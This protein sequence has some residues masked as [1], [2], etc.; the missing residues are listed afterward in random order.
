[1]LDP[2]ALPRF[3]DL[4][5]I[6]TDRCNLSC[7]FCYVPRHAPRTMPAELALRA[8]DLLL[9]RAPA[10]SQPSV[11]FFGGEPFLEPGLM[12]R[13]MAHGAKRR[14]DLRFGAPTNGTLVDDRALELVQRHRLDLALSVDAGT[15]GHTIDRIAGRIDPLRGAVSIARM[16]V[17]PRN[18]DRLFEGIV[19]LFGRGLERIMHQPALEAPWPAAAVASW[20]DQ[21]R[22]LADWACERYAARQPLPELVVLE[23]II[24]R[25]ERQTPP[26]FCGAGSTQLAVD[27]AGRVFGCFRSAYDPR[28]GRLVLADLNRGEVNEPLLAAYARLDPVRARP[29]LA[30]RDGSCRGCP[31]R[32]GCTVYCP[33]TGHVRCGDLRAVPADACVL[34][35]AQVEICRDISRR[36]K[37]IDRS[38]RRRVGARVA[39][40]TLALG[41]AAG[42]DD[43]APQADQSIGGLCPMDAAVDSRG[44]IPGVCTTDMGKLD[45]TVDGSIGPGLCPVKPDGNI[46]PGLCPVTPD[47]KVGPGLCPVKPDTGAAKPDARMGGLCPFPGLC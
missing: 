26:G 22:R 28:A 9:E 6:L 17:T 47:F 42:C 33:A 19:E 41:L 1:M 38:L 10:E 46:G 29:E 13:V 23:G 27:P 15:E 36:C 5:L 39:A 44:D 7:R 16:T 40:A 32:D 18:V 20:R 11:S 21:H 2:S 25:L 4:T 35:G 43:S 8:V 12:A 31:A 34:M 37:R 24:G 14:P 45:S 3:S 30:E